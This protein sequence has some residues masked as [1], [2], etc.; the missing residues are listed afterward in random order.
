MNLKFSMRTINMRLFYSQFDSASPYKPVPW[1]HLLSYKLP[2]DV[3]KKKSRYKKLLVKE[4]R[5]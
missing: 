4:M 1:K 3:V 2:T 5:I